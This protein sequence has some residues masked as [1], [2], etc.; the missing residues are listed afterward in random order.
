MRVIRVR[1]FQKN[2]LRVSYAYVSFVS[3]GYYVTK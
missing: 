1:V 3:Q 2:E